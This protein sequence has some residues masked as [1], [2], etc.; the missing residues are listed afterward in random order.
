MSPR[1]P[2]FVTACQQLLVLGVICAALTPAANIVSLELVPRGPAGADGPT[3]SAG[4]DAAGRLPDLSMAAY[5]RATTLKAN[6]PTAVV[7]PTIQEYPLTAPS[8]AR[9]A[10]G[11]LAVSSRR[12]TAGADVLVSDPQPVTG[13]G[14]VGVTWAAD[15]SG[16]TVPEGDIAVEV[17]TRDE[18][19]W[20]EWTEAHYSD[21]HGPDPD[22]AEGV[23]ARPGTDELLVG[24][25]DEVQ[26][27]V[28]S[29]G[30]AP[31]DLSLAVIDPG[32]ATSS[33]REAAAIDTATLPGASETP[34]PATEAEMGAG[35]D[36]EQS[37]EPSGDAELSAGTFTPKPKIFSRAQWGADESLRDASSLRYYEVH[38]G[39]VH[40]TVNA[41]GYKKRDV[42]AI[43][44][45]IYAYHTQSRGWSDI[46]Y[47]F[48]V[49]RFG[50]VWEGR[51]GGVARPVVGA[52]TLGYNDDSFAMS[53]IG[54]F[55]EVKPSQA[56]IEAYAAVFAW[57]LSL[58]GVKAG[59]MS[60]Y[61]TS[62]T[63]AAINGHRDAASTACPGKYLYAEIPQIRALAKK[64]QADFSGRQLES[65]V[66]GSDY[67][68]IFVRRARDGKAML[69]PINKTDDGYR[70]GKAL[71]VQVP[72]VGTSRILNA[73]DW[74]RDGHT[75]LITRRKSDGRL[76]LRLGLG[77]GTFKPVRFLA[78]GFGGVK[79]LSA[80]GD[81]TGDGYPD[82]MGQPKG[83]PMMIYPGAWHCRDRDAVRRLQPGQGKQAGQRGALGQGRLAGHPGAQGQ[84]AHA[85]Q[86]QRSR[87]FHRLAHA[88]VRRLALRLDRGHQRRQP[89]GSSRPRGAGQGH[90][91]ALPDPRPGRLLR[92][93]GAPGW[94]L[95]R[96]QHGR[97]GPRP[98][99][100]EPGPQ[101]GKRA[102][103][104]SETYVA[105]SRSRPARVTS[106]NE[107]P[108]VSGSV[109]VAIPG[110][111]AGF[112]SD[113]RRP[114]SVTMVPAAAAPHRAACVV[115]AP[116]RSW[117]GSSPPG[118]SHG[119][120]AS[121]CPQIST[122]TSWTPGGTRSAK[123]TPS[124]SR[125]QASTGRS[126]ALGAQTSSVPGPQT[127]AS[128][129]SS[130]TTTS[131][132]VQAAPRKTG[133]SQWVGRS[134]RSRS[135]RS[136]PSSSTSSE[137]A[138]ATQLAYVVT[139]SSTRS[140]LSPS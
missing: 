113:R 50:R 68:D 20:S 130:S 47:N 127:T 40:H 2:R 61:V 95:G 72:F 38:A 55:E 22:S 108:R 87:R 65:D 52:H 36:A 83:R 120:N 97:V 119:V 86:R 74:D 136:S 92:H 60:Q 122:P 14:A 115:V 54:N 123:R 11:S 84:D 101:A 129:A 138:L 105:S 10:P 28:D 26:V 48:L 139:D 13:Y 7:D 73:G 25:V 53:A 107:P 116:S 125:A 140:P 3:Q 71:P 134:M 135:P 76:S 39:F 6:V 89:Q 5:A 69:I 31:A 8:G 9:L 106:T 64:A 77:N 67:P 91:P 42:P 32:I 75:D 102:V 44:R 23:R 132:A 78:D 15:P 17:R 34:A 45:G 51:F 118:G 131:P 21:Q 137:A 93:P 121:G 98:T 58:H 88:A 99:T 56:M 29:A 117:A 41:N 82:L 4:G 104:R 94:G 33:S 96:L 100:R 35:T 66:A 43:M 112:A 70:A 103:A 49:D 126:A 110:G 79:L 18:D 57:K 124:G 62:R 1:Y 90:G 85:L 128:G 109:K 30:S 27:R 16:V 80:V 133:P 12:T 19:G 63:F 111:E 46:G 114:P 59:S 37:G 81:M 24:E